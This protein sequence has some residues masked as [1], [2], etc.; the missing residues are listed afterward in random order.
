MNYWYTAYVTGC[1]DL[2]LRELQ[3]YNARVDLEF[4]NARW[5]NIR[6]WVPGDHVLWCFSC[7]QSKVHHQMSTAHNLSRSEQTLHWYMMEGVL[8]W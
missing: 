4:P 6:S 7:V 1:S 3:R 2:K 8:C 5:V